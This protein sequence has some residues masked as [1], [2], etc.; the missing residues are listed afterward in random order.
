VKFNSVLQFSVL[1]LLVSC[2]SSGGGALA[3]CLTA[4][5]SPANLAD[6]S[7]NTVPI[8]VADTTTTGQV[9]YLNEPLVSVKICT[10]GFSDDDHCQIVQNILLD[11]GSF[12]LRVFESAL[13]TSKLTLPQEEITVPGEADPSELVECAKFGTGATWGPVKTADVILGDNTAANLPI[14]LIN[15]HYPHVSQDCIDSKPET[16]PCNSG[17]NGI[18]GVGLRRADC[19]AGCNTTA[20]SNPGLYYACKDGT[21]KRNYTG[22]GGTCSLS[23]AVNESLQV[24]NPVAN[25]GTGFNNGVVVS[26][27]ALPGGQSNAVTGTMTLGIPDTTVDY[28]FQAGPGTSANFQTDLTTEGT[29]F[30]GLGSGT[31]AFI[32]SGSNGIFFGTAI[33]E[34]SDHEC[35]HG[36]FCPTANGGHVDLSADLKKFGWVGFPIPDPVF[37]NPFTIKNAETLIGSGKTA[38]ENLGGEFDL[39]FDWG[40]PFYFGKTI[41]H[42]IEGTDPAVL[43]GSSI[44]GPYWAIDVGP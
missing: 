25:F 28:V 29:H 13:D 2:N 27:N 23:L 39:I 44:S 31:S 32:D 43:N 38:H 20:L 4:T 3:E 11:T 21:C 16:D 5:Q 6:N 37:T 22:C 12:G 17:F 18:L 30:G 9:G 41:Y 34:L 19:G 35:E 1:T 26:F 40:L 42:G 33:S 14:Q 10:P 36:F 7:G 8:Y 15:I 24:Y